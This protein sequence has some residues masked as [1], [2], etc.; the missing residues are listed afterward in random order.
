MLYRGIRFTD[1]HGQA[2]RIVDERGHPLDQQSAEVVAWAIVE[3]DL[4]RSLEYAYGRAPS[5]EESG[6]VIIHQESGAPSPAL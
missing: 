6:S 4:D 5:S 2:L 3:E 1:D